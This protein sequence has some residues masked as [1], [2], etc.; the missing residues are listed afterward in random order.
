MHPKQTIGGRGTCYPTGVYPSNPDIESMK[1]TA[2]ERD[3]ETGLDF[4]GARYFSGAQG[5]FTSA[6]DPFNDQVAN[7][8][9]SWNLYA[10]VRNNPLKNV[11]PNGQ[12]CVYTGDFSHSG[13]VGL[14]RG[15]CTQE[16]GQYY[17]GTIN[18]NSFSY[19]SNTG[20]LGFS[21]ANGDVIGSAT[22][23][24]LAPPPSDPLP[25][26]VGSMLHDAGTRA[27][28]DTR[29]LMIASGVFATAYASTYAIPAL[30]AGLVTMGETGAV[31]PGVGLLRLAQKYGLNANS[32]KARQL[33]EN[34]NVKVEDFVGKYR[35]GSI[36][37]A[38]GWK[39]D[40]MTVKEALDAGAR[41][42]LTDGRFDK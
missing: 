21:Y 12:D 28:R 6:D 38:E 9:Q 3:A 29:T 34:L 31:G 33:L 40:G 19:N 17:E 37:Q 32:P 1:F 5:R 23:A 22:I 42:L 13:T 8:P 14:E 11:D 16:G 2:K 35:L 36:K 7:D 26:G 4:F 18:A 15:D 41:K 27:S 20:Q 24:G 10:Y 30:V 39:F 25:P